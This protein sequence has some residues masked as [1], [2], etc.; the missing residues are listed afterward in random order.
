M[1][2]F[3]FELYLQLEKFSDIWVNLTD[4]CWELLHE[5]VIM[6]QIVNWKYPKYG[7]GNSD[8]ELIKRTMIYSELPSTT[9][10]GRG[11]RRVSEVSSYV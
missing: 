1:Y 2:R 3:H 9:Y 7:I 10:M 5:Y 11:T 4:L 6:I 8:Y